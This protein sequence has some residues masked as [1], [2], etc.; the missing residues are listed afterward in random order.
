MIDALPRTNITQIVTKGFKMFKKILA[1]A[2]IAIVFAMTPALGIPAIAAEGDEFDIQNGVLVK[3]NGAGGAVAIPEGVTKIEYNAF[4]SGTS[5]LSY[6]NSTIKSVTIPNS[7]TDVDWGT[8]GYCSNLANINVSAGNTAYSSINGVVFSKD[9][10]TLIRYPAG[11]VGSYTVPD[12]VTSIAGY[13]QRIII[14]GV[15]IESSGGAFRDNSQVTSVTIPKSV[16]S[17]GKYAVGWYYLDVSGEYW[18]KNNFTIYGVAGSA[19]ETYAKDNNITFKTGTARAVKLPAPTLT[20]DAL[21]K[22]SVLL[23]WTDVTGASTYA[24]Y[25][26]DE[27]TGKYKK[28]GTTYNTA[29]KKTKLKSGTTYKFKVAAVDVTNG[30]STIGTASKAVSVKTK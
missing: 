18:L 25:Q 20:V 13:N 4:D 6:A 10:K 1:F 5:P 28:L 27:A 14:G 29:Y 2:V 26:L 9:G 19:A 8:F 23:S 15:G 22:T 11:R 12:G 21:G 24:I 3:Y 16:T 7:L 17:I 30:K